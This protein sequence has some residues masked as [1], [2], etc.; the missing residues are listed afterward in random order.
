MY[1]YYFNS[2][3]TTSMKNRSDKEIILDFTSLTEYLKSGGIHPG[4]HFI[5]NEASTALKLTMMTNNIKYQLFPT[6]NHRANNGD[7]SIQT[8]KNHFIAGL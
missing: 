8:F 7:R 4:F 5:E 3:L 6:T 1:V 2:I